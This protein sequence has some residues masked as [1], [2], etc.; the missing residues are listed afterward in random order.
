MSPPARA[1]RPRCAPCV[2]PDADANGNEG[3]EGA[4]DASPEL[5]PLRWGFG[6]YGQAQQNDGATKDGSDGHSKQPPRL[7]GPPKLRIKSTISA[8]AHAAGELRASHLLK[9]T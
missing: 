5:D 9:D 4:V 3:A 8:I 6:P 2:E 1:D 7:L